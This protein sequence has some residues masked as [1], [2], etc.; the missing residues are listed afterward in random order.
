MRE[1]AVDGISDPVALQKRTFTSVIVSEH[2][3]S[4]C[5]SEGHADFCRHAS[6]K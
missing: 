3:S 5:R 2:P 4:H 1:G 6:V